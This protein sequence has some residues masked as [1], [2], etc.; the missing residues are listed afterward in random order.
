MGSENYRANLPF[1]TYLLS[2]FSPP[3]TPTEKVEGHKIANYLV[4]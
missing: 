1:L 4:T 2:F 3:A